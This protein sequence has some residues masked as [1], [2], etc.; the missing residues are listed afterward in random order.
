MTEAKRKGT[1]KRFKFL[2]ERAAELGYDMLVVLTPKVGGPEKSLSADATSDL[3]A[4]LDEIAIALVET[5]AFQRAR[6]LVSEREILE[7]TVGQLRDQSQRHIRRL[8][9]IDD[10]LIDSVTAGVRDNL[11]GDLKARRKWAAGEPGEPVKEDVLTWIASQ[12]ATQVGVT[13]DD[14]EIT[15]ERRG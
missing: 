5:P 11:N 7:I 1:A 8:N 10:Q 15:V 14:E 2:H 3:A 9:E 4:I 13:L 12:L 6:E